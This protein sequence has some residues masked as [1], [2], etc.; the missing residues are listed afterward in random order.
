MD[1]NGEK[2]LQKF[3]VFLSLYGFVIYFLTETN[4]RTLD[5]ILVFFFY[6]DLQKE[7]KLW[8][9]QYRILTCS[10]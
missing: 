3:N 9:L 4:F 2:N 8:S 5:F 7:I 6:M 10:N 1:G